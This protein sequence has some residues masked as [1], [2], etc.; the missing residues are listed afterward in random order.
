MVV[1]ATNA[2]PSADR[3]VYTENVGNSNLPPVSADQKSF[4]ATVGEQVGQ[5]EEAGLIDPQ[6]AN[7]LLKSVEPQ[8]G[9]QPISFSS[10]IASVVVA[11]LDMAL[12][13]QSQVNV[14]NI[15]LAN[16]KVDKT[17][18]MAKELVHNSAIAV[19]LTVGSGFG[20]LAVGYGAGKMLAKA[21]GKP[22]TAVDPEA[23]TWAPI[24]TN[25]SFQI[26]QAGVELHKTKG[27]ASQMKG[28][29]EL[30]RYDQIMQLLTQAS[31]NAGG[32]VDRLSQQ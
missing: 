30:D 7:L 29:S 16:I 21:N 14:E 11:M 22:G 23:G 4:S 6:S 26:C 17:D 24:V 19:G 28:Q 15:D 3:Q 31:N 2:V 8:Q 20:S 9:Y 5:L 25:M 1:A 10:P 12:K 18:Q 27:Q 13:T 32:V